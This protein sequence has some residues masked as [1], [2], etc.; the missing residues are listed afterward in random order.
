M[1]ARGLGIAR[2]APQSTQPT[3]VSGAGVEVASTAQIGADVVLGDRVKVEGRA[4]IGEGTVVGA[5]TMIGRGAEIGARVRIGAKVVIDAGAVIPSDTVVL[6]G[7]RVSSAHR[8]VREQLPSGGAARTDLRAFLGYLFDQD[9][10]DQPQ[11][12]SDGATPAWKKSWKGWAGRYN[13]WLKNSR[14]H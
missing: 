9:T 1:V 11:E 10:D 8:S 13:A 6:A 12:H 4:T 5:D 7:S 2:S 3:Y 14:L